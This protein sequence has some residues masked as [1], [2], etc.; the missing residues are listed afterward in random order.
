MTDFSGVAVSERTALG[1]S[2]FYRA[3][4]VISQTLASLALQAMT[5]GPAGRPKA[6]P[7]VF[8]A[9]DGPDGQTRFEW[10][11]TVFLHLF[12]HGRAYGIKLVN[13]AGAIARL[14]LVHPLCV[15]V[16][17]PTLDEYRTGRLP[18]GGKWFKVTLDDGSQKKWDA[19]Q[20]WEVPGATSDGL[21]CFSLIQVA[22]M[23]LGTSIAADRAAA[24]Q[25]SKGALISGMVTPEDDVEPEEVD[26]IKAEIKKSVLGYE[27][28]GD[29]PVVNRRL[30]FTPWSMTAVD[31]QFL[32][33]RQFQI[34]EVSRWTGVPPHLLMQTEKQTSWGTGVDEQQRAMGRTVL[35]PYSRRFEERAS[36]LLARPRWVAF[37]FTSLERP[38]PDRETE[39]DLQQV[40]AGVMT[41]DEY[42]AKRGWEPLPDEPQ[43]APAPDEEEGDDDDPAAQ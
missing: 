23:S 36:R 14:P 37:D 10:L 35:L 31:A 6:V 16:E 15:Q 43:A 29:L 2:A 28:A 34:E 8:D 1:L 7:S 26:Q 3:G 4:T 33:Q 40:S 20:I 25:L 17:S 24:T 13:N 12:V 27:N 5:T 18:L 9:P 41:V 22:R 19:N 38:S 39:L 11:E 30:K 32:Q 42:R 21:S